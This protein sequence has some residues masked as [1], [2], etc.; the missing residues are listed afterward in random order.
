VQ[1]DDLAIAPFPRQDF[2]THPLLS[3]IGFIQAWNSLPI[4]QSDD[5]E[6]H[7]YGS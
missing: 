2:V 6:L 1:A 7:C 4:L 3:T 5:T